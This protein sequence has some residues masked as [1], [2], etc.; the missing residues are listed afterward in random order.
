MSRLNPSNTVIIE[1][2]GNCSIHGPLKRRETLPRAT[3]RARQCKLHQLPRRE[4]RIGRSGSGMAG[5]A[6]LG[7]ARCFNVGISIG[8]PHNN[9]MVYFMENPM[10]MD[11]VQCFFNIFKIVLVHEW[12][13]WRKSWL[14]TGVVT[15][16]LAVRLCPMK[17]YR[18]CTS[19]GL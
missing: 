15:R 16:A 6:E 4:T 18:D 17:S 8:I 12:H 19:F 14:T 7:I 11:D 5:Q 3:L 2:F 13:L 9:W 1:A 10:K